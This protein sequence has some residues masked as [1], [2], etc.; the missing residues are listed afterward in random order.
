VISQERCNRLYES[1]ERAMVAA[2]P[3]DQ[4]GDGA[5]DGLEMYLGYNPRNAE[6]HPT[7]HFTP[8]VSKLAIDMRY[9]DRPG[10]APLRTHFLDAG[11]RHQISGRVELLQRPYPLA[12]GF[13]LRVKA[14]A[15]WRLALPGKTLAARDLIVPVARD[16]TIVFDVQP[17]NQANMGDG[18]EMEINVGLPATRGDVFG[19]EAC[20]YWSMPPLR[21]VVES[22]APVERFNDDTN[23]EVLRFRVYRLRWDAVP[24]S[25]EE[26]LVEASM[27]GGEPRWAAVGT[28]PQGTTTCDLAEIVYPIVHPLP[29]GAPPLEFRVTPILFRPTGK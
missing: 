3:G 29:P 9:L 21:P 13:Q 8:P 23:S 6:E 10:S 26:V 14:G 12:A 18:W 4:D 2:F 16:G 5:C 7:L 15:Y 19:I 17:A 24:A 22:L 20:R 25:A 27:P 28:Y 11:R 1:Y